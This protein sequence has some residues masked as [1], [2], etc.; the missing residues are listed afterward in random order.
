[1][2]NIIEYISKNIVSAIVVTVL[3]G[4]TVTTSAAGTAKLLGSMNSFKP[5]VPEVRGV[6]AVDN[7]DKTKKTISIAKTNS[8]GGTKLT[9]SIPSPAGNI[10][11]KI[12]AMIS[13]TLAPAVNNNV[14]QNSNSCL[15]TLFGKEYDVFSLQ[16]TH[17][18]GNI[19]TC[20]SD[21]TSTYQTR[22]GA[23]VSRMQKYLV[24]STGTAYSNGT[25]TG[26]TATGS[27]RITGSTATTGTGSTEGARFGSG[28][29]DDDDDSNIDDDRDESEIRE[30][31]TQQET[32]FN[33]N[34]FFEIDE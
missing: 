28:S 14:A 8:A 1:M 31:R 7:T 20:N 32:E 29:N 19:F 5:S 25:R 4:I 16:T 23:D 27:T 15:I 6:Q 13:P 21:M 22:H 34:S 26:S 3:T 10:A 12:I 2:K 11:K 18:G 30:H 9:N 24:A 17:S 33:S